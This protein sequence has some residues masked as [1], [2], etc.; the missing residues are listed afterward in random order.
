M[1]NM[2]Q[3]PM[4]WLA[5]LKNA[6]S[7]TSTA[8]QMANQDAYAQYVQQAIEAGEQPMSRMQFMQQMQQNPNFGSQ[9]AQ[10]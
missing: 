7:P 4:N 2:Q 6:I 8:G 5:R 9:Y 3:Q 1:D 10:R